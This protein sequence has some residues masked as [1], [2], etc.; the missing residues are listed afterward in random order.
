M[1]PQGYTTKF[2]DILRLHGVATS[3]HCYIRFSCSVRLHLRQYPF[4]ESKSVKAGTLSLFSLDILRCLPLFTFQLL[5]LSRSHEQVSGMIS[6]RGVYLLIQTDFQA[7]GSSVWQTQPAFKWWHS[8]SS[9]VR[10][11]LPQHSFGLIFA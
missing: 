2:F 1:A 3:H 8:G 6:K 11:D 5:A 10:L 4:S 7:F 9:L